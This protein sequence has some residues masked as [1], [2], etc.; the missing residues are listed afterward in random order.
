[1]DWKIH[2]INIKLT[3]LDKVLE[4]EMHMDQVVGFVHPPPQIKVTPCYFSHTQ[5]EINKKT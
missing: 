5:E 1:M 2:Q 3:I 4:V